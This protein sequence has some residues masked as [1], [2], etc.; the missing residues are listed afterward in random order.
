MGDDAHQSHGAFPYRAKRQAEIDVF[1]GVRRV[2]RELP[3]ARKHS[4]RACPIAIN[5]RS[6]MSGRARRETFPMTA[7]HGVRLFLR[8]VRTASTFCGRTQSSSPPLV[9]A[10]VRSV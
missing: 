9:W 10:S 5:Q 3:H 7:A 1:Q 2:F 8:T 4:D 6:L